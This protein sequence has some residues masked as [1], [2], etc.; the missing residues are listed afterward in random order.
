[1]RRI[2]WGLLLTGGM[3]LAAVGPVTPSWGQKAPPV[4]PNPQAPTLAMPA[5]LGIQRGTELELTL[6]GTNLAQPTGLW[7]SFPAQIE[8]PADNKNGEDNT[9]LRVRLRVAEDAPLGTHALRLATRRGMSNV[10]LFCVDE[11]PQ[12]LKEGNIRTP[13]TAQTVPVPCVVVGRVDAEANDYYKIRVA[14]GQRVSFDVLGHRLGSPI[15]PQL[16]LFNARTGQELPGGHSNDAPG[17][18]TDPRLTYTFPEAGEYLIEV[19]DV[20]YRGGGDYWYRLRIGDFPCVTTPIP[21]AARRGSKETVHFAGPMVEGVKPRTVTIPSDP[22]VDTVWLAPQGANGLHGWPVPL[23]ISDMPETVEKEPNNEPAQATRVSVPGG[24]TGRFEH[25]GDVDYYA[26]PAQKGQRIVI[27]ARTYELNSPTE[28]YLIVKDA[29]GKELSKSNPAAEPRIDFTAPA[30]GDFL[31]MVEHLHYWGGP[32][33]TYHLTLTPYAP[34]FTLEL[35]L[36][37]YDV[38]QGGVAVLFVQ[39]NRQGYDGPIEVRAEGPAHW[40]AQTTIAAGQGVGVLTL[41]AQPDAPLGPAVLR[42]VGTATI[43]GQVAR[44]PASVQPVLVTALGNLMFPPRDLMDQV[45]VAVCEPPPITLTTQLQPAE[46]LRGQPVVLTVTADRQPNGMEDIVLAALGLPANVATKPQ[47][48]A[49]GKN[50][51]KLPL[52]PAANAPLGQFPI[53]ITGRVKVN[54]QDYVVTATPSNLNIVLP[55]E[56]KVEP[57]TLSLAPGGKTKIKVNAERKAGYQGPITLALRNLP[58]NVTAPAAV[59]IPMGQ[60]AAEVEI[61]AAATAAIGPKN[62]VNVLGTATAAGNQQNASPNFTLEVRKE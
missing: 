43:N 34:S 26:F 60:N 57:A 3:M 44:S 48:I 56:L 14:A 15:D 42:V 40:P 8:I 55:F 7:T 1:M 31:L 16:T 6:T 62:D 38:P 47:N 37:R 27:Q 21:M 29:A 33:E 22:N 20:Q 32:S 50:D 25:K 51:I 46:V 61:S 30:D 53:V 36:D 13:Q 18:Q 58:G 28:V 41:R 49:K 59:T 24:V 12:V 39:A 5:P 4:P 35:P 52:N 23:V 19:R 17:L 10:R 45:A 2:V 9:K 11:L 54:N